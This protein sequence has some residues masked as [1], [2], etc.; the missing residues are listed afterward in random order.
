[1]E[2]KQALS[3][4][5]LV[6]QLVDLGAVAVI[7]MEQPRT[8]LRVV[9]A[10]RA[11]GVRGIEITM[12]VPNALQM[13]RETADAYGDDVLLGVGSVLSGEVAREAVEAGARF[14]VSPVFKPEI[15]EAA[16]ACGVP[17]LPGAFTPTEIQ[18]AHE[19]GADIVKVFPAN[20]VGMPFFKAVLAPL[21]HLKLMPTGGLTLANAGEWLRAGAVAVGL[22]S[23]LVDRQ[24]VAEERYGQLT[25]NARVLVQ[26]LREARR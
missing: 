17:A 2:T 1:M 16:H 5:R 18:A 24:A 21:P 12:T 4:E 26:G 25:E 10:L 3:R 6:D 8:L 20:V 13:I 23:T 7:R 9:D 15:V 11:G 14:V 22:G 19:A